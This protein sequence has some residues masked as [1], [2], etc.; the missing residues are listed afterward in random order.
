MKENTVTTEGT[1]QEADYISIKEAIE[2]ALERGIK[3]STATMIAWV[4]Q[5]NL[6]FQ[7]GGLN[8]KWYVRKPAFK[9][10]LDGKTNAAK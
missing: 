5:H 4:E 6:G 9:E 3:S 8:S 7:P 10:F 2:M 1:A